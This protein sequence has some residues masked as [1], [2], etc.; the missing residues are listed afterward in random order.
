MIALERDQL[1][2]RF[3]LSDGILLRTDMHR[4]RKMLVALS[5]NG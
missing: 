1:V 4:L 2:F 3:S 5:S